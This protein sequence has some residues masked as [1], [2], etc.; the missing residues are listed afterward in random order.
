VQQ[1]IRVARGERLAL[2]QADVTCRGHAIEC[3]INAE[4]PYSFAPSP[5]LITRWA[6]P[7]GD[8]VRLDSHAGA[9]YR[10]PPYYDSLI[11]KLVV[12]GA[13]R[14]DAISRMRRALDEMQVDG[15]AT[16]LPLHRQLLRDDGFIAGGADIHHLERWLRRRAAS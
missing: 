7:G 3:R 5:G 6:V 2:G 13:T 10:V 14:D 12:H 15:I 9:D 16:N 1:Q 8:G 4:D 11:A